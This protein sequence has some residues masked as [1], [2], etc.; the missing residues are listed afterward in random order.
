[1]FNSAAAL[2]VTHVVENFEDGV[3]YAQEIIDSKKAL[4]KL[5]D[6]I[7]FTNFLTVQN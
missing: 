3:R 2:L 1:L 7:E 5:Q 6:M 4:R